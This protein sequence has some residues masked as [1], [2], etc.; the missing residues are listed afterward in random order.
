MA[1]GPT[2]GVVE[3]AAVGVL[4][5]RFVDSRAVAG[6]GA[7]AGAW[8]VAG[9]RAGLLEQVRTNGINH[10][11]HSHQCQAATTTDFG[12]VSC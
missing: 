7:G 10:H 2:K 5:S 8:A 3:V 12:K 6:T 9:G 11:E 4:A 1:S